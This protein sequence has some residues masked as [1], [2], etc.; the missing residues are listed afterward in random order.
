MARRRN[1]QIEVHEDLSLSHKGEI[2]SL[3]E[4]LATARA[5]NANFLVMRI[6]RESNVSSVAVW[7]PI[8]A[9]FHN[10]GIRGFENEWVD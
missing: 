9:G 7:A 10:A 3:D 2:R 1:F 8:D 4:L 6:R 5:E